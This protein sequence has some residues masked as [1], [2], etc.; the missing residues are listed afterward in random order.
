MIEG[1]ECVYIND[2]TL[3]GVAFCKAQN[4]NGQGIMRLAVI[5]LAREKAL[6]PRVLFQ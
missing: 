3:S 5:Y 1:Y 4:K 2:K 6:I